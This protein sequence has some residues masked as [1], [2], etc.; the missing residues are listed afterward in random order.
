LLDSDIF[1]VPPE[2]I[3]RVRVVTTIVG[4]KVVWDG[5]QLENGH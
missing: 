2:A 5:S 3:R 4:G 1:T